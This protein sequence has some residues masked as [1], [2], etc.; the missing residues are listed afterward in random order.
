MKRIQKYQTNEKPYDGGTLPEIEVNAKLPTIG[1]YRQ[2]VKGKNPEF[3]VTDDGLVKLLLA[4][5]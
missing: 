3:Q 2:Y 1:A 5:G 4:P